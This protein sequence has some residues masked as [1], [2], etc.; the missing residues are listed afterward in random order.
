MTEVVIIDNFDSFVYNLYQ[1]VGEQGVSV[2]VLRNNA[3]LESIKELNPN[4]LIIS[5]GPG[6]PENA[7]VSVETIKHFTGKIPILGVCLGHQAIGLAFGAKIIGADQLFHG[8][9]SMIKHNE[10]GIFQSVNNPCIATRYHSLIIGEKTF[11][12]SL[13]ITARTE[14]GSGTI[15]AIQ[16]NTHPT[17]G[18]QF[19]PESIL[20]A[21]GKKIVINFLSL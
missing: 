2:K 14:D 3:S 4:R 16:H 6:R 9:T 12:T 20:T 21:E 19:H 10:Q 1:Y 11:P 8:K 13:E 18:V 7:G 5:P 15:M 17:F